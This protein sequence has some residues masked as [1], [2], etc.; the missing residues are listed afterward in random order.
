MAIKKV[1]GL[2]IIFTYSELRNLRKRHRSERMTAGH[3]NVICLFLS[4]TR[5]VRIEK[6]YLLHSYS[7][8]TIENYSK[9]FLQYT[10]N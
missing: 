5:F 1:V 6:V 9:N 8:A 7:K 3:S 4:L 2:C 10:H